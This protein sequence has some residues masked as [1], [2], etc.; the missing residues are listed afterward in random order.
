MNKEL[1]IK[2]GKGNNSILWCN[3]ICAII[4]WFLIIIFGYLKNVSGDRVISRRVWPPYS[5]GL[6]SLDLFT[7]GEC[8]QINCTVTIHTHS[9]DEVGRWQMGIQDVVLSTSSAQFLH[10]MNICY[11]I[12]DYKLFPTLAWH[13]YNRYTTNIICNTQKQTFQNLI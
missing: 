7:C 6:T 13:T 1:C 12:H 10:A 9:E 4:T 3:A 8:S 11:I 2:V 5:P